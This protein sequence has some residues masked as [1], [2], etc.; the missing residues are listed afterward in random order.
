MQ[1]KLIAK[2]FRPLVH[3][4]SIGH[5]IGLFVPIGAPCIRMK[6]TSR[7]LFLPTLV[8]LLLVVASSATSVF[9]SIEQGTVAASMTPPSSFPELVGLTGEEAKADLERKYPNLN[10]FVVPDGSPVT[11][12]YREDRVR[13]FVNEE[14]KV[15]YPPHIG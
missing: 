10:V 15:G 14:G 4:Q 13:I 1:A 5:I 12:D 8:V 9:G 2:V 11:M 3:H 6:V 7:K